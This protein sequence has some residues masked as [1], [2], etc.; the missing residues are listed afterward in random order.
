MRAAVGGQMIK[1]SGTRVRELGQAS[2]DKLYVLLQA[3]MDQAHKYQ[4]F[5]ASLVR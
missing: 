5:P 4:Q 2:L 3:D 1:V